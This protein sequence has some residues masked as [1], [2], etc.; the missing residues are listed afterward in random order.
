MQPNLSHRI[1]VQSRYFLLRAS[2]TYHY[3]MFIY[4]GSV[5]LYPFCGLY[6]MHIRG[7]MSD[8]CTIID[9]SRS[10]IDVYKSMA[11]AVGA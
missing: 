10:I 4:S 3:K 5:K 1:R 11:L 8:A 7:V 9:D 2:E 6:Y